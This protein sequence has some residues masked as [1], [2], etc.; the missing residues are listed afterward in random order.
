MVIRA[1][2]LTADHLGTTVRIHTTDQTSLTGRLVKIR[3]MQV[4]DE[5]ETRLDLEVLGDQLISAGFDAIGM[6]ELLPGVT[7]LSAIAHLD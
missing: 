6:V 7:D 3:H 4:N 2:E 5:T 1:A